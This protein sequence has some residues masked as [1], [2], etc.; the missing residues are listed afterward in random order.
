MLDQNRKYKPVLREE[1][2][3]KKQT[4]PTPTKKIQTQQYPKIIIIHLY[5]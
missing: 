2:K 5:N 3:K 4:N 1:K